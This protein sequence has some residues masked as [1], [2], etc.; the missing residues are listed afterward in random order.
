[1]KQLTS[2]QA[3]IML[4]ISNCALKLLILPSLIIEK[5][6]NAVW[7]VFLVM[8]LIDGLF[9]WIILTIIKHNPN[10]TFKE[11]FE[12]TCGKTL[13]KIIMFCVSIL[14]LVKVSMLIRE[15][16]E[17]YS[18]TSYV[19]LKWFPFLVPVI[20]LICYVAI[21]NFRTLGRASE[22]LIYFIGFALLTSV[23]L[24]FSNVNITSVLPI[25]P[26][27]INSVFSACFDY[28]FWFGDFILLYFYMGN[29]KIEKTTTKT[30]FLYWL[31]S[32]LIVLL[33][34]FIHFSLFGSLSTMFKT[35]IVDVTEYIPRL[36]T[37]GRFT[38]VIIFLWPLAS[39]FTMCLYTN[40]ASKG[41]QMCFNIT[42]T[43]KRFVVYCALAVSFAILL[44]TVFSEVYFLDFINQYFKY[45][46]FLVQYLLAFA[47]PLLML[48]HLK[49]EKK[50]A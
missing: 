6:Q 38:W 13:C 45:F 20:L 16:F 12:K 27:G 3:G 41:L 44:I 2:R 15:C 11:F 9:L 22:I 8:F 7:I 28:A 42:H 48:K 37:S 4:F 36:D 24:S 1:M 43:N 40:F 18:E 49:K 10:L 35:S 25:L 17:F 5:T 46:V 19:D 34:A 23:A 30:I 26:K 39:I 31:V 47:L 50:N 14:C 33:I 21:K 32:S 29:I